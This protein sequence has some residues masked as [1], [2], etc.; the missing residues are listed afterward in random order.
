MK[1]PSIKPMSLVL[2]DR[3]EVEVYSICAVLGA[4]YPGYWDMSWAVRPSYE[5][6]RTAVALWA[7]E[8]G[9]HNYAEDRESFSTVRAAF[10]AER[11]GLKRVVVE[12]LS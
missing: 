10:E 9:A 11:L 6:S 1:T 3:V 4:I 2:A 5:V 7:Q 12:D 8:H